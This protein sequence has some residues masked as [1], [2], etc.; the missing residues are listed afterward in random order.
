M[1][2]DV[3]PCRTRRPDYDRS[4]SRC[5]DEPQSSK[6]SS[7]FLQSRLIQAGQQVADA[8]EGS[9]GGSL[10]AR[11]WPKCKY[12]APR[13]SRRDPRPSV[14][15]I[16]PT[17]QVPPQLPLSLHEPAPGRRT[18]RGTWGRRPGIAPGAGGP[19]PST[20]VTRR[21]RSTN[22][23]SS[24]GQPVPHKVVINDRPGK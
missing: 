23:G 24:R 4:R 14:H 6:R 17:V 2:G 7:T 11:I 15:L 16:A 12:D 21:A 1:L 22:A 18:R 8:V 20:L 13:N 10:Q 5:H 19:D 3:R 9:Y